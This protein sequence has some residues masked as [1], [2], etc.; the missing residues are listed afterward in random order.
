MLMNRGTSPSEGLFRPIGFETAFAFLGVLLIG[1]LYALTTG[2]IAVWPDTLYF[3]DRARHLLEQG[4]FIQSDVYPGTLPLY[5][6]LLQI[7]FLFPEIETGHRILVIVQTVWLSLGFF[8]LRLL[9]LRNTSLNDRA[10]SIMAAG[11]IL[12]PCFF[13]YAPFFT[14]EA[15]YIPLLLGAVYYIDLL[16][17][18]PTTPGKGVGAGVFLGLALL[19]HSTAWVLW[20]SAFLALI[21]ALLGRSTP[22]RHTR[23]TLAA[24]GLP[25]LMVLLWALYVFLAEG[26]NY[27]TFEFSFNNALA[28][29]NFTKNAILYFF[30]AGAPLAGITLILAGLLKGKSFWNDG[31]FRFC[32]ITLVLL[33]LYVAFTNGVIVERRLDYITN[34]ALEPFLFLPFIAL[35]RINDAAQKELMGNG[36]LLLFVLAIFGLPYGL[37]TDFRTGMGFWIGPFPGAAAPLIRD[38]L[39]LLVMSFPVLLLFVRPRWFI[40]AYGFSLFFLVAVGLESSHA[41]WK[42]DD[43]S[44]LASIDARSLYDNKQFQEAPAIYAEYR[45]H[46]KENTDVAYLFGCFDIGKALY[47]LPKLPEY[48]TSEEL[49]ELPPDKTKNALFASSEKDNTFGKTV[50]HSELARFMELTPASLRTVKNMP[51]VQ[52][53]KISGMRQYISIP[54]MNRPRRITLLDPKSSFTFSSSRA[55]C[56]VIEAGFYMEEPKPV[57]LRLDEG[58]SRKITPRKPQN[59]AGP[60]SLQFNL[61]EGVSTLNIEYG[62]KG[63]NLLEEPTLILVDRPQIRNCGGGE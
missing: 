34:R 27:F 23:A 21:M 20:I 26:R 1:L 47:F 11:G 36:L 10:A 60:F 3:A 52:I 50:A 31:F 16:L 54:M 49:L 28:R 2:A 8:P 63:T 42:R 59:T 38:G 48:V 12:L 32:F 30:Y 18:A 5:S 44:H 37:S 6:L 7:P 19:T 13:S 58:G 14:A 51:L 35:F 62:E 39:Y 24:L 55:G 33:A 45:C 29:F 57:T 15:L 4:S 61:P 53:T 22:S 43:S 9:L 17:D 41:F 46:G 25:L 40:P 56:V